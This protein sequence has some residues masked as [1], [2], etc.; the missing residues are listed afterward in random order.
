MA[1]D[2]PDWSARLSEWRISGKSGSAWCRDNAI[3][4]YQFKYWQK[5]LRPSGQQRKLGRFVPLKIATTPLRIE[6]NGVYLHISPG[7][8]PMLLRDIVSVLRES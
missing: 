2:T 5:K 7:F 3:S 8:D 6:C 4:Y 1:E